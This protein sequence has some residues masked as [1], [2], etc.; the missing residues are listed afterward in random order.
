MKGQALANSRQISAP[1]LAVIFFA[2]PVVEQE[3]HW[4]Y[5][6]MQLALQNAKSQRAFA[7]WA[8]R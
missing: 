8:T 3:E 2:S 5:G 4:L 7:C 1:P 6:G